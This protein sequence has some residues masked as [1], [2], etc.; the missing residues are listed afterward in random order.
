MCHFKQIYQLINL[1]LYIF[2][3][4]LNDNK[5]FYKRLEK[6]LTVSLDWPSIYKFKFILKSDSLNINNLINIF[7][8]IDANISSNLS[9]SKNFTSITITAKMKSANEVIK[10]YKLA[11]EIEGII[12]L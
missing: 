7:N 4:M 10:K 12:S 2:E 9:S 1:Y 11:S 5:D 6:Q 8:D 3:I